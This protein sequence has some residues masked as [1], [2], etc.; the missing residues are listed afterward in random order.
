[1]SKIQNLQALRGI[2]VLLVVV[3]HLVPIEEKYGG[4]NTILPH[5]LGFGLSGVDLFFVISGFVMVTVTR[6]KFGIPGQ[7]QRFLYH[8]VSRIYPLYWFYSLLVLA[9]FLWQPTMIN[10][11]QGG[12]VNLV[13][14]FLLWP[15]KH[16]PLVPVG[17]TLI[18]EMYF[19]L[20]FFLLFLLI[21]E[22][23]LLRVLLGWGILVA[24]IGSLITIR[25]PVFRLVT[26]PLTMEFIG[27][28]LV[29]ILYYR[30]PPSN[31]RGLLV[32]VLIGSFVFMLAAYIV[33]DSLY[34]R[35]PPLWWRATLFGIPSILIVY[36]LTQ[37][38]QHGMTM[39][40]IINRIGD[41]SYSIYLSHVLV[42]SALGRIWYVFRSEG[43]ID[44]MLLLPVIFVVTVAA[45]YVGYLLVERPLLRLARK[46]G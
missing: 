2:A 22:K 45:G 44:N 23:Y 39:P 43:T 35:P 20:V 12:Q 4:G 9:V 16:L 17:W 8:R 15:Q 41:A 36:C 38:E 14:S 34:H 11:S 24:V 29:A 25:H 5:F 33:F 40:K 32:G 3:F 46:L 26:H 7:A 18:H 27:G 13:A 30:R 19:Y 31:H 6:G 28:A 42:L 21:A 10:S 37:L 1:L